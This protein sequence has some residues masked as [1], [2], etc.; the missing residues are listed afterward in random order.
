VQPEFKRTLSK[1]EIATYNT[2]GVLLIR[3]AFD[4]EWI[5]GL[6][7][8]LEHNRG[9]PTHRARR[10][11]KNEAGHSMFWDSQ[12]WQGVPQYKEFVFKSPA[13]SIAGQLMQAQQVN[14]FFDAVFVRSPGTQFTTPWHQDEPYWSVDG[15]DT[16]TIWMPLVPVT[17]ASALAFVPGSHRTDSVYYQH[18]FGDLNPDNIDGV[19]QSDFSSVGQ[20][21]IPDIDANPE[22]YNVT[23]WDMQPGDCV[24]F[25]G[26]T[27]HG[28]SGKLGDE[29]GLSVFTSKWLGDDAHIKL[30]E[31]G[32]DP[33]HTDCILAAGLNDGDRPGTDLYPEIWRRQ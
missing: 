1:A 5:E 30:R 29:K 21:A 6:S 10:W 7:K 4:P 9:N 22:A 28:G 33:D 17:K 23:S 26:R 12:A 16:L 27:I 18:N 8:G 25:N 20:V 31:V 3:Q 24:V 14:F 2:D 13:A 32:M 19:D 11:Y 15:Y